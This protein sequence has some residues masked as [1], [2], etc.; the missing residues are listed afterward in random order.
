MRLLFE[1]EQKRKQD[2]EKMVKENREN[3]KRVSLIIGGC[4]LAFG[5]GLMPGGGLVSAVGLLLFFGSL[6]WMLIAILYGNFGGM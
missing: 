3:F 5:I 1:M 6:I 2:Q 4:V